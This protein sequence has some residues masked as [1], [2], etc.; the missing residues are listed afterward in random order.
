MSGKWKSFYPI[1]GKT[2]TS[3]E[4]YYNFPECG[5]C[6]V[7]ASSIKKNEKCP[8]CDKIV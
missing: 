7:R 3:T 1:R 5:S 4:S 6:G 8:Y 2:G